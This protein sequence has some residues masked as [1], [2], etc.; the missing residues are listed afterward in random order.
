MRVR[1][2]PRTGDI[3]DNIEPRKFDE[4]I[5]ELAE[6]ATNSELSDA[7]WDLLDRVQDTGKGGTLTLTIGVAFDGQGRIQVK[8]MVKTN[9]PEF[10][11]V[12]TSFFIDKKGNPTR[13]DPNQPELPSLE[14]R[15]NQNQNGLAQ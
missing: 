9:L 7:L 5:R 14:A 12:P 6:G 4:F 1:T 13:R 15:R 8:D 3:D 10:S 2:D 11:R